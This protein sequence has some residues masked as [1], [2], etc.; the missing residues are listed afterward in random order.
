MSGG[1]TG[2]RPGW[3][4]DG[5]GVTAQRINSQGWTVGSKRWG[6]IFFRQSGS[7]T[8]MVLPENVEVV[9]NVTAKRYVFEL[10]GS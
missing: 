4:P 3:Y 5:W 8:D 1:G 9:G 7:F 2:P 6:K 10:G